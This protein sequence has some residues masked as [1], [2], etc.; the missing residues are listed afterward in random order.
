[1]L[2][3]I[4]KLKDSICNLTNPLDYFIFFL[5]GNIISSIDNIVLVGVRQTPQEMTKTSRVS[6]VVTAGLT[7][8]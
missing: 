6:L 5:P 2:V 3:D 7:L 8:N 1:M 4:T